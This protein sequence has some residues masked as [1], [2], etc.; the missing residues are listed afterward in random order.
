MPIY[1]GRPQDK[2]G[3]I[4]DFA[5]PIN[6]TQPDLMAAEAV[7]AL[8]SID[9]GAPAEYFIRTIVRG[10]SRRRARDHRSKVGG[11]VTRSGGQRRPSVHNPG[12]LGRSTDGGWLSSASDPAA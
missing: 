6:R 5:T 8:E 10:G 3:R 7:R 11:L 2:K 9:L 4:V 1:I 12:L